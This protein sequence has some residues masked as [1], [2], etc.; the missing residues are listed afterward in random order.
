MFDI[1]TPVVAVYVLEETKTETFRPVLAWDDSGEPYVLGDKS[2]V[3][4]STY[5]GFVGVRLPEDVPAEAR[6]RPVPIV[7]QP[8]RQRPEKEQP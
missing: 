8:P 7:V 6:T 3:L 2:L 5:P 1:A 4:A